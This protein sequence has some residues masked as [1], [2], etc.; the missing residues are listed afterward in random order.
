MI[1]VSN[2]VGSNESTYIISHGYVIL[3][4]SKDE[5][6]ELY[7]LCV[8]GLDVNLNNSNL[9]ECNIKLYEKH[10]LTYALAEANAMY[11][12]LFNVRK[13]ILYSD[14][15]LTDFIIRIEEEIKHETKQ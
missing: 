2:M 8:N 15:S 5:H 10:K 11:S 3:L 13:G 12:E 6:D 4:E 9:D 14:V 1:R 7:T